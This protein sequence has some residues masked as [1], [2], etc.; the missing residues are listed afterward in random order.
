MVG[1]NITSTVTV[2]RSTK[3]AASS[4]KRTMNL[5]NERA[6]YITSNLTEYPKYWEFEDRVFC[7]L[8]PEYRPNIVKFYEKGGPALNKILSPRE[9]ASLDN[10]SEK[11]LRTR[12]HETNKAPTNI[13]LADEFYRL[14]E[15]LNRTPSLEDLGKYGKY[16]KQIWTQRIG[17]LQK[18]IKDLG[19][20]EEQVKVAPQEECVRML[21][22]QYL[23]IYK[24]TGRPP[25][26]F[27][28]DIWN[29]KEFNIA[30]NYFGGWKRFIAF[31]NK[32][33]SKL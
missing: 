7:W 6:I 20:D 26:I 21:E 11:S 8:H 24:E 28:V 19:G 13:Q 23:E 4:L 9:I 17:L 31:M 5:A 32:N 1:I 10:E 33:K 22:D 14:K 29:P 30:I 3:S 25:N 12:L 16:S 15:Q 27:E 18:I 2:V